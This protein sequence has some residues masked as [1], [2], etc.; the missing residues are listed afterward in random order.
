MS[1]IEKELEQIA[2]RVALRVV[3]AHKP[4]AVRPRDW[5]TEAEVADLLQCSTDTVRAYAMRD[6]HPLPYGKVGEIRRYHRADVDAWVRA[7]G[8]RD[9]ERRRGARKPP[10]AAVK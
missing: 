8:E 6:E 1:A 9:R 10:L 4:A 5:L 3:E 7:E 2:E